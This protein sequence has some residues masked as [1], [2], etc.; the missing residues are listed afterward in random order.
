MVSPMLLFVQVPIA[1]QHRREDR[2]CYVND[3]DQ[4]S[5]AVASWI[6]L[7]QVMLV[8]QASFEAGPENWCA[9]S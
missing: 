7:T 6:S 1:R 9:M 4:A 2:D 3:I 5:N 8:A